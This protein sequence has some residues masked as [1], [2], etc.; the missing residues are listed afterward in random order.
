[1][2]EKVPND[3]PKVETANELKPEVKELAKP[4]RKPGYSNPALK[5]MGI[6]S[7]R[8][9]SRN[10]LIF[11]TVVA[12]GVG[13]YAFDKYEQGKARQKWMDRVSPYG[14]GSLSPNIRAR[15]VT[16]YVAP[17]PNDYLD[18]S[19]GV[20]RRYIKPVLNA[21][22]VDFE[23]KSENRQGVIRSMVAADI[24]ALRRELRENA[25]KLEQERIQNLWYNKVKHWFSRSAPVDKELLEKKV[26]EGQYTLKNL[27]GVYYKNDLQEDEVKNE[28]AIVTDPT[29]H[30]GV[31]CIGRGAYKE[32]LHGLHE[33]L[34]GP[35]EKPLESVDV[36][37]ARE[38]ETLG[39]PA[40][41]PEVKTLDEVEQEEQTKLETKPEPETEKEETDEEGNKLQKVP[42][43]F[44]ASEDYPS[45][46]LAPELQLDGN[47]VTPSG[48]SPVFQ[49]PVLVIPVRHL[50][51]FLKTP[52]RIWRFYNR[53]HL[54]EEY[55]R[56]A[57]CVVENLRGPFTADHVN[58][59]QEEEADWPKKWV[60]T[61]KEKGSEWLQE[62][63]VDSRVIMLL[64]AFE[65]AREEDN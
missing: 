55:G 15:K 54:V 62:P 26:D 1:M 53:R 38:G 45:A 18:E 14:E 64:S 48:V 47:I 61:G 29:G 13:G 63:V 20:F 44:I 32:Y 9:P 11:W 65:P 22:G 49:Q 10:W 40:L 37:V 7:I 30:G 41:A 33:G 28:D 6:N 51:G 57:C 25:E 8:F 19:M 16:V 52:Q 27:L 4:V 42:K 21:G 5:A 2:S 3:P 43:P 17:P 50:L 23:I 46:A 12:T 24:R 34:L 35:L 39:E 56:A 36:D 60:K 31:I 59:A 58:W